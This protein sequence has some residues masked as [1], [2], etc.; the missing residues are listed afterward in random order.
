MTTGPIEYIV[1]AF[2]E[3]DVAYDEIAPELSDLVRREVVSIL[4]AVV[5]TKEDTGDISFVEFD[6]LKDQA[7]FATIDVEV[8]GLISE[9]DIAFV[10]DGLDPGMT[11]VVFL[12]EDLWAASLQDAVY[13]SGGAL[14]EGAR[15]PQDLVDVAIAELADA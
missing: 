14:L 12:I 11:A 8:G 9:E 15:I 1:L 13:R 6:E 2:P 3:G 4:D 7:G 5:V 10:G